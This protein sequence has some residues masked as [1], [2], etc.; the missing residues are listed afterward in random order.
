MGPLSTRA[1]N[2]GAWQVIHAAHHHKMDD[3]VMPVCSCSFIKTFDDRPPDPDRDAL[4]VQVSA[5]HAR[6]HRIGP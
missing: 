4:S 1:L 2:F 3:G 6:F 5:L